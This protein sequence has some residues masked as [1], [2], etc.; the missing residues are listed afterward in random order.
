MTHRATVKTNA[1]T[2]VEL[3]LV[4]V[5]IGLA[6]AIAGPPLAEAYWRSSARG[7]VDEFVTTHELARSTAVRYGRVARLRIDAAGGRF[8]A[9][10]DTGQT[11]SGRRVI[12]GVKRV[13]DVGLRMTS[14]R[15]TICFDSRGLA[16]RREA[17]ESADVTVIFSA[18]NWADTVEVTALGKVLR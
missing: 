5:L 18:P 10:V 15:S 3:I 8:W 2:L 11:G 14:D 9:E 4:L 12:G 6:L 13:G 7:A 1:F 16:T 17:C